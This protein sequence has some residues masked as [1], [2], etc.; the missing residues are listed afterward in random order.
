MGVK[1]K[2]IGIFRFGARVTK[3]QC[4][5]KLAATNIGKRNALNFSVF[6]A[7]GVKNGTYNY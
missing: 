1:C 4:H 7:K 3:K 5:L 2:K 6:H